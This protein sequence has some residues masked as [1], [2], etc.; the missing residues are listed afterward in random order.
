MKKANISLVIIIF[1]ISLLL[2]CSSSLNNLDQN[3]NLIKKYYEGGQYSREMKE[4]ITRTIDD[5]KNMEVHR[6]S[7]VIFDVDD[8]A[9][10]NY[11][12]M[13]SMDFGNVTSEWNS[14]LNKGDAPVIHEVKNL[15]DFLLSRRIKIIF[16]TG[17]SYKYYKGTYK[18]LINTGYTNFDTLIVRSKD[19]TGLSAA[20]YK[21]IERLVLS[22]LG[23]NII[24]CIGDQGSD[25]EGGNTGIK[26]KLPNYLYSVE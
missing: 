19:Q 6:N 23:Y 2:G 1:I 21:S 3:K 15:Y 13:K 7:V 25:L 24:G 14:Y 10:S 20:N 11:D 9:I 12:F 17:R 16:L 4:I 26:I 18:N 5:F 8:T 22:D